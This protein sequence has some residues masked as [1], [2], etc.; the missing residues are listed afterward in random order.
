MLVYN[1]LEYRGQF[2]SKT[3]NMKTALCRGEADCG[4]IAAL[5]RRRWG[6]QRTVAN[7]QRANHQNPA[8]F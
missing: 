2:M 8:H 1:D 3:S 6:F 7:F 5:K 4:G